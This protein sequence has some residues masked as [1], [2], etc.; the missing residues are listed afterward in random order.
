MH[1][2]GVH[3]DREYAESFGAAAETYDR[4]R[5]GYAP[6]LIEELAAKNPRRVLDV[7]CGTGKLAA[8]FLDSARVLGVE[9]DPRMAAVATARGVEVELGHFEEWDPAGRRFDLVVS[10]TAWHWIEPKIGARKAAQVLAPGGR[11]AAMWNHWRH[12]RAVVEVMLAAYQ[13]HAPTLRT[14]V[15]GI[16]QA[17]LPDDD[18]RAVALAAQG[19][20]GVRP[21]MRETWSWRVEHTADSWLG[22]LASMTDHRG[23]AA[24][25]RAALFDQLRAGLEGLGAHFEVT[26]VTSAIVAT[27][28]GAA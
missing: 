9:P 28:D 14:A 13:A 20:T 12:Q 2:G 21:G 7:G 24:G 16:E 23:L 1:T 26:M 11:F 3:H 22:L 8:A 5:P 19:F 18:V 27:W 6:A 10:G 4:T 15:L 25:A 17:V